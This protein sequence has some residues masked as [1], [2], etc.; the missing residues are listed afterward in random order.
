MINIHFQYVTVNYYLNMRERERC[1]AFFN[2]DFSNLSHNLLKH[3][4]SEYISS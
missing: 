3:V 4:E 2:V 1:S